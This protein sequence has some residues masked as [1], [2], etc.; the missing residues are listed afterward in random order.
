MPR[1]IYTKLTTRQ[2]LPG[3][4]STAIRLRPPAAGG[5]YDRPTLAVRET[6]MPISRRTFLRS[7]AASALLPVVERP[8]THLL[9]G[10]DGDGPPLAERAARKGL[11]Y[12]C[13]AATAYLDDAGFAQA[14]GRE[15]GVLVPEW[16]GKRGRIER[17][18]GVYDYSAA[19]RLA[20]FARR[21]L[22]ALRGHALVWHL[23]NPG[24]LDEALSVPGASDRLITDYIARVVG[25]YRGQ[26]QSWDVVNEAVE[27]EDGRP[28]G[29][30]ASPWLK[31][32]GPGYIDTAFHAARRADA[33]AVLVYNDYGLSAA[34]PWSASRRRA[35]LALLTGL[36]RRDTPCHALGI[37]GHLRAFGPRFDPDVF[38]R[39]LAEVAALRYRIIITELDVRDDGGPTAPAAR[40]RAVADLTRRYLD[41]A[42]DQPAT[43]GVVTWGLSDRYTWLATPAEHRPGTPPPRPLP[44]DDALRRKP[45]WHAIAAAFDTARPRTH[46]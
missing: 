42:L 27:V 23:S 36:R 16:E 34:D 45:M 37:Q 14:L 8:P 24:W 21:H 18:P 29:L 22:M 1:K 19:D 46:G 10:P 11:F 2:L 9:P 31:A 39:F 30:R 17:R 32:F 15:A 3:R 25:H 35:V 28:D 6:P 7:A 12:G 13:C 5:C 41:V 44:L 43:L 26:I 4:G 40:D 33:D 38:R 20:G